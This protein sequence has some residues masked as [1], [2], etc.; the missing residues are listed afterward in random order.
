ML[1]ALGMGWIA[2]IATP[3]LA[4]IWLV[5]PLI[6]A[7]AGVSMAM[8]AAQNAVLS[9]VATSEIGQA[10]GLFN[11]LRFL[12]G[13][14][15]VAILAAAFAATGSLA[16]PA[17]F[18]LGFAAAIGVAAALSLAAAIAGMWQPSRRDIVLPQGEAFPAAPARA[19]RNAR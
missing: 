1:Q 18:S 8:P 16:S 10:S 3:D 6:L 9:A 11:M 5:A 7:G 15:G 13:A 14:F 19:I 2:L 12:G 4:Y 17:A